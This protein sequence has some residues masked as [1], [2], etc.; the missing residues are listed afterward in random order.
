MMVL[1]ENDVLLAQSGNQEA[2]IRLIRNCE[3]SLYRVAKGILKEELD[4]ADAIQET[5]LKS[6]HSISKLKNPAY[7]KTWLIRILINECNDM[8][9]KKQKSLS[10]NNMENLAEPQKAENEF[11]ELRAAISKLNENYRTVVVL[12]YF[13]DCSIKDIAQVLNIREGTVKSRLNRARAMLANYLNQVNDE[14][15]DE[16]G[17]LKI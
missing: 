10:Y 13:E 16:D 7:F 2:F 6:Y 5:I 11:D 14:G 12:F 8:L 15:R 3:S 1:S 4:C 9:K 17:P